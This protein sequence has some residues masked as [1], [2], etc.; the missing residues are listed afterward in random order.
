MFC[1]IDYLF[2]LPVKC[3]EL[4][5]LSLVIPSHKIMGEFGFEKISYDP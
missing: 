4:S 2:L 3:L 5:F 1:H